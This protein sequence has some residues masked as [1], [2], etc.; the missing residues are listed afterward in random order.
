MNLEASWEQ[1]QV[2]CKNDNTCLDKFRQVIKSE[3]PEEKKQLTKALKNNDLNSAAC[4]IHKIKHKFSLMS[5]NTAYELAIKYEVELNKG[6]I[7]EEDV[8]IAHVEQLEKFILESN[9]VNQDSL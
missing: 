1:L 6:E 5:M 4:I 2:I 8:F 7:I 3:L 9:F